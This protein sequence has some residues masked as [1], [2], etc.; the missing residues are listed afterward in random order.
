MTSK[1]M[2][3]SV[4]DEDLIAGLRS[5]AAQV[6]RSEEYVVLAALRH[7]VSLQN[8]SMAFLMLG[9]YL[10]DD[11]GLAR[12][13]VFP[14]GSNETDRQ[15]AEGV[16]RQY[17]VLLDDRI[18]DAFSEL[19]RTLRS[20]LTSD[21][22]PSERVGVPELGEDEAIALANEQLTAVRIERTQWAKG[23]ATRYDLPE[24]DVLEVARRN[25]RALA[26]ADQ[27]WSRSQLDEDEA[28]RIAKEELRAV[29]AGQ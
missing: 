17:V 8:L 12:F 21:A 18:L 5:L 15:S 10:K 7:Y 4:Q 6:G 24:D 26:A 2:K 29:R 27:V 11:P 16:H 3:L 19:A 28:M 13:E 1:S 14:Y 9:Q 23:I 20:E 22:R 25:P